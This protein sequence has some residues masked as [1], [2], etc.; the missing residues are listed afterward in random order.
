MVNDG[1]RKSVLRGK[2]YQSHTTAVCS[3]TDKS[4]RRGLISAN[5]G[6]GAAL[7]ALYLNM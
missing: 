3:L 2:V 6:S 4:G 7:L 1:A 5:S